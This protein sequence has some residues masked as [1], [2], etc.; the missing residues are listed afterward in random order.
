M[1]KFST[2]LLSAG[3]FMFCPKCDLTRPETIFQQTRQFRPGLEPVSIAVAVSRGKRPDVAFIPEAGVRVN[4]AGLSSN[5]LRHG[6]G[7]PSEV[8]RQWPLQTRADPK[9]WNG[10][11]VRSLD[12]GRPR[13]P[14]LHHEMLL[15]TPRA[16]QGAAT[17]HVL[18]T[19]AP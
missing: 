4:S 6:M 16:P 11:R 5:L 2:R 19:F 12:A 18:H 9:A 1:Y 8:R 10:F 17:K 3:S 13:R 14:A 15:G 7:K